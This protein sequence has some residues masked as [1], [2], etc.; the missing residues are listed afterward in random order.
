MADLSD[1]EKK[2]QLLEEQLKIQKEIADLEHDRLGFSASLVDSLKEVM[3]IKSS[4]TTFEQ[5]TLKVNQH[6]I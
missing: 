6:K 5:T 3:G 4:Q 2:K 1:E